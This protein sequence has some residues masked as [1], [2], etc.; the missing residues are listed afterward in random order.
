MGRGFG[1]PKTTPQR[2][3]K[4]H[5][6]PTFGSAAKENLTFSPP[7]EEV[8]SSPSS[9]TRY[10]IMQVI[11]I[12]FDYGYLF[13][14]FF[15]YDKY[16]CGDK[17][18]PLRATLIVPFN[19]T[20][21]TT[22]DMLKAF[23]FFDLI[24]QDKAKHLNSLKREFFGLFSVSGIRKI[25][26]FSFRLLK[27]EGIVKEFRDKTEARR[28]LLY[29][30]FYFTKIALICVPTTVYFMLKANIF[31]MTPLFQT[32]AVWGEGESY[33]TKVSAFAIVYLEYLLMSFVK[34]ALSMNVLHQMMH[35]Q[36]YSL[37]KVHHMPM[38]ELSMANV[39]FFDLPDIAIENVL[40]PRKFFFSIS[41][42]A[43]CFT[44]F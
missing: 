9:T 7:D 29:H 42:V 22:L 37:H 23:L 21:M 6:K 44:H 41:E 14:S 19:A 4:K 32:V 26:A 27:G 16:V 25:F 39:W 43:L 40:S 10:F 34:D 36:F 3:A 28:G 2:N 5:E 13:G 20:C 38:R 18:T 11:T 33:E 35:R 31:H 15:L 8:K 1:A 12:L 30:M 17:Y 24:A